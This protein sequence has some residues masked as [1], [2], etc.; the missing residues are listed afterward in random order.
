MTNKLEESQINQ[1]LR[2]TPLGK[3]PDPEDIS[4]LVN[5]LLSTEANL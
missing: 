2:R 5:Y 1:I 4:S 3:L